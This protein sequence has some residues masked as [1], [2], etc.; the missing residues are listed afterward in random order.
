[1]HLV[2]PTHVLLDPEPA[3]QHWNL[4]GLPGWGQQIVPGL[5]HFG[6]PLLLLQQTAL[7]AQHSVLKQQLWLPVQVAVP[8]FAARIREALPNEASTAPPTAPPT[9]LNACRLGIGLA[10]IRE[11]SSRR[12]LISLL[13]C[14]TPPRLA[15]ET[16]VPSR[17][18][19]DRRYKPSRA[20]SNIASFPT[21]T[22]LAI[23]PSSPIRKAT[24]VA[25]IPYS[26]ESFHLS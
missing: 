4:P 16:A 25:K 19:F 1:M 9:S 7:L 11:I 15:P 22:S 26:F 8:Q 21:A 12:L 6:L 13:L 14:S 24:G 17:T 10:M 5:Q 18:G 23:T 2:A 3:T 20:T